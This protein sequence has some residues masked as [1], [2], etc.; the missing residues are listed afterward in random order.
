MAC[1]CK[2][3]DQEIQGDESVVM[4]MGEPMHT[5]CADG[6]QREY[7]EYSEDWN[8]DE[9]DGDGDDGRYDD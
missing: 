6:F 1:F 8:W 5:T 3:C 9:Y 4:T 2:W 7:D